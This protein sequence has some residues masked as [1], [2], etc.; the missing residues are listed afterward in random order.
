M[1]KKIIEWIFKRE[2]FDWLMT[3]DDQRAEFLG[4]FVKRYFPGL[5]IARNRPKGSKRLVDKEFPDRGR[6]HVLVGPPR[7]TEV[8]GGES[9]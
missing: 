9:G 1:R 3:Q 7:A 5:H 4:W 6:S 8:H 2:D